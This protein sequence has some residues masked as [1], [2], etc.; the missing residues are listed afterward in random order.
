MKETFFLLLSSVLLSTVH[1]TSPELSPLQVAFITPSPALLVS[2]PKESGAPDSTL[3]AGSDT[4]CTRLAD[5][6][7]M[8][9]VNGLPFTCSPLHLTL[10]L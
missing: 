2:N 6:L 3:V 1:V 10:S 7:S 8:S 9:I 5:G 4:N